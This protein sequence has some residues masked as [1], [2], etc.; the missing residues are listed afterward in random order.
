MAAPAAAV[1]FSFYGSIIFRERQS[2]HHPCKKAPSPVGPALSPLCSLFTA[3]AAAR[4][5]GEDAADSFLVSS[6]P[7]SASGECG[8][9]FSFSAGRP[10]TETASE[11][12]RDVA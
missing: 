9:R 12:A 3:A 1:A 4:A 5:G 10:A 6:E 2:I 7:A 8:K 11:S